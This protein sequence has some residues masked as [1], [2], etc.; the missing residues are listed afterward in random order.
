MRAHLHTL[1]A[2]YAPNSATYC[3]SF[4]NFLIVAIHMDSVEKR[5]QSDYFF[6]ARFQA[7]SATGTLVIIYYCHVMFFDFNS[8]KRTD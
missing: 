5:Y 1:L 3:R 6:R 4:L 8:T 7:F 2:G